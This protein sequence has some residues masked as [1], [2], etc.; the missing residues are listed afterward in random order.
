MNCQLS[1]KLTKDKINL[2]ISQNKFKA[3]NKE[4][5]MNNQKIGFGSKYFFQNIS[6]NIPKSLFV[7]NKTK[8]IK[9]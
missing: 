7:T 6:I 3:V 9:C 4:I 1:A 2:A 8:P 5:F